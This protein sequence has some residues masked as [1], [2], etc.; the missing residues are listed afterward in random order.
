MPRLNSCPQFRW[1]LKV[2]AILLAALLALAPVSALALITGGPGNDPL[3]AP[4]WPKGAVEI[5]NDKSRIAYW[6]GPPFGG[7]EWHAEYRGDAKTLNDLLAKFATL[8]VKNKRVVV[9]DGVG[10]SFWLNPNRDAA[11][12]KQAQTD[13]TFMVWQPKN[14]ES[15]RKLPPDL[16]PTEGAGADGPPSQIDVYTGGNVHWA[17]VVVPKELKIVDQRLE[18]HGFKADDKTV[19]EG[20]ITDLATNKPLAATIRLERIEPQHNGGYQYPAVAKTTADDQGHWILKNVPGGSFRIVADANGYVPRVVGYG[21]SDEQPSWK[22]YSSGLAKPAS[23][24]GR[25]TDNEGKPLADVLVR[26][27]DVVVSEG[28]VYDGPDEYKYKT[29]ADGRFHADQVPVGKANVC[30]YKSG[31]SR[32]GFGLPITMPAND[33]E[34]KMTKSAQ[35]RVTVDFKN[36]NRP[37]GYMVEIEPE[38]GS[39]PGTWGGSGNINEKNQI[40]FHDVPPGKYVLEGH[41]NPSSANQRTK[42]ITVELIGGETTET[43]IEAK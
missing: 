17:D 28:G 8:D 11:K 27:Q 39:K 20:T 36:A 32:P 40:A 21:R 2:N 31:Y 5:F 25:V 3:H 13:W 16:N 4:G 42:P 29:D 34:L 41:P 43:T 15:L 9:H 26:L 14:W 23:V 24:A 35:L 19:L 37:Q 22:S 33:V 30:V 38:G 7:G 18:A 10:H 6:E 12:E 1:P